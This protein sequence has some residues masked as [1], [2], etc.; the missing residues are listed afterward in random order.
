MNLVK[1]IDDEIERL[2]KV[3]ALLNGTPEKISSKR[4]PAVRKRMAAAQKKRW[5]AL[6]NKKA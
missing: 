2:Q 6:K 4:S 3:K 1:V 5:A